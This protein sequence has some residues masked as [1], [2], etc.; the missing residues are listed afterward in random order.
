MLKLNGHVCLFLLAQLRRS[1]RQGS[2]STKMTASTEAKQK[3]S[4]IV[5]RAE[6]RLGMSC[7]FSWLATLCVCSC[8]S[9]L[10]CPSVEC[11]R[12]CTCVS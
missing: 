7:D 3:K 5:R 12:A 10:V 4:V 11:V 8:I 2:V 1:R 6:R 9:V